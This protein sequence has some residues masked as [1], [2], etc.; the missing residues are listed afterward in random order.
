MALGR[1]GLGSRKIV[2]MEQVEWEEVGKRPG[3]QALDIAP[4]ISKIKIAVDVENFHCGHTTFSGTRLHA[5]L[6][7][8]LIKRKSAALLRGLKYA[9]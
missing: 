1:K 5:R 3:C 8:I 2:T 4:L 6:R 7:K 9:M